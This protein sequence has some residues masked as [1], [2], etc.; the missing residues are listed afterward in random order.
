MKKINTIPTSTELVIF[1]P[2]PNSTPSTPSTATSTGCEFKRPSGIVGKIVDEYLKTMRYPELNIAIVGVLHSLGVMGGN[3]HNC[4]GL[5]LSQKRVLL[6]GSGEGKNSVTDWLN[7]LTHRL[8]KEYP[9][10]AE[11]L[12]NLHGSPNYTS[13][14]MLHQSL[15]SYPVRS[16]IT[17]EAGKTM[18]SK[19][20][21]VD[22]I[23]GIFLTILGNKYRGV[24]RPQGMAQIGKEVK[25][26]PLH[27]LNVQ[28]LAESVPD[29]YIENMLDNDDIVSGD[30]SRS[31]LVF[32]ETAKVKNIINFNNTEHKV[33]DAVIDVYKNLFSNFYANGNT[34][35]TKY[36]S[37]FVKV[38]LDDDVRVEYQKLEVKKLQ[39]CRKQ[40][41]D[42]FTIALHN[43]L[44]EKTLKT[45]QLLAIAEGSLTINLEQ[46]NWAY[47]YQQEIIDTIKKQ[48]QKGKFRS[49][50]VALGEKLITKGKNLA[51]N[52]EYIRTVPSLEAREKFV[53]SGSALNS[54]IYR[55]NDFQSLVINVYRGKKSEAVQGF[56]R[57]CQDID[58]L[59]KVDGTIYDMKPIAYKLN[60]GV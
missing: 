26:M 60:M 18:K 52:K 41:Q 40:D 39:I 13:G 36:Q 22:K 57:Y 15:Q 58:I 17:A 42:V 49:R 9:D 5:G 4:E 54:F 27:S 8:E 28:I 10:L 3:F 20:G 21:D 29:S 59:E 31:E 25:M 51:T 46:W 23:Q 43:R 48:Q 44:H 50:F 12:N 2:S 1:K 47:G 19:A 38:N 45:A 33:S 37:D 32:I 16:I 7:S 6:A 24:L 30:L 11:V 35:P 53:L 56:L 14:K 55:H 34:D